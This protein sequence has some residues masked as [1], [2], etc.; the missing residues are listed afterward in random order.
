MHTIAYVCWIKQTAC[1]FGWIIVSPWCTWHSYP[2]SVNYSFVVSCISKHWSHITGSLVINNRRTGFSFTIELNTSLI[3]SVQ[4]SL[5]T[6]QRNRLSKVTF[7]IS[8]VVF[9]ITVRIGQ[10]TRQSA[11]LYNKINTIQLTH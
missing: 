2:V 1:A 3:W 6:T 4:V 8:T 5:R 7:P 9:Y 11:F 10:Q